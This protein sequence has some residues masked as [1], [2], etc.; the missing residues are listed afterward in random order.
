[1]ALIK[2][3]ECGKEV[4]DKAANCI[5]CGYP[6]QRIVEE[7]YDNSSVPNEKET[8]SES[9]TGNKEDS[10]L[11]ADAAH[12]PEKR[13]TGYK[14]PIIIGCVILALVIG[15]AALAKSGA[16]PN[17]T[18][19]N[20]DGT[21]SGIAVIEEYGVE[22]PHKVVVKDGKMSITAG[23]SVSGEY[24]YNEDGD[25]IELVVPLDN[26]LYQHF[27]LSKTGGKYYLTM[28][29]GSWSEYTLEVAKGDDSPVTNFGDSSEA[30]EEKNAEKAKL[31]D[32]LS[33]N[34]Y[35]VGEDIE[36]GT[37][38]FGPVDGEHYFD[39]C[40]YDSMDYYKMSYDYAGDQAK[41]SDDF[42]EHSNDYY[43]DKVIKGVSLKKGNVL[44]V[45][46]EGVK[47]KKH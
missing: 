31:T 3:P 20:Y 21:Y 19:T 2:C 28:N 10:I 46:Y 42:F 14:I 7:T 9:M 47:Y 23:S 35:V 1:M 5:H 43:E 12:V 33:E 45:G 22:E 18:K 32:E 26:D 27:T 13:K 44:T 37:Y 34:Y 36:A 38:D 8:S 41:E 11:K 39:I 25:F 15:Y 4:S 16:G 30:I 40:I 17:F 6:I 24:E 29:A